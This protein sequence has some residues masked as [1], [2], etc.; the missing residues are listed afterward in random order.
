MTA[1]GSLIA[2]TATRLDGL[3]IGFGFW[4]TRGENISRGLT[5]LDFPE[6]RR[7]Q[8]RQHLE[9]LEAR[10][11]RALRRGQIALSGFWL[12]RFVQPGGGV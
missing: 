1:T 5:Q 10:S 12:V 7:E 9:Q 8:I 3:S 11:N 2:S 4:W 6:I